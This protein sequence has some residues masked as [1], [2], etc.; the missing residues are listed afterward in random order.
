MFHK[1]K[2]FKT[3]TYVYCLLFIL[4]YCYNFLSDCFFLEW[5][6]FFCLFPH[7]L[8]LLPIFLSLKKVKTKIHIFLG[9]TGLIF[10]Q[11]EIPN[12]PKKKNTKYK[13]KTLLQGPPDTEVKLAR[14]ILNNIFWEHEK[15]RLS[16]V[17]AWGIL[18]IITMF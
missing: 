9:N 12:S 7:L 14:F 10:S 4:L 15:W 8:L 18:S 13:N 5:S 1:V 11:I 16:N 17:L 6:V 3:C 2:I